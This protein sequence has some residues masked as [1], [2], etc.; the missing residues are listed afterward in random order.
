MRQVHYTNGYRDEDDW[1]YKITDPNGT[2]TGY[3]IWTIPLWHEQNLNW[4]YAAAF[5][6]EGKKKEVVS[7]FDGSLR[8]RQMVTINNSDNVA[9]VQETVF[10][11]FGRAAGKI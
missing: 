5:S 1:D 7:Y 10:D 4:Q 8:T 9:V 11:E 6:E 3:A 2:P